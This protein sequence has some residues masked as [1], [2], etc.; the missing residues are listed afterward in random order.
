MACHVYNYPQVVLFGR[1]TE[2]SQVHV[3]LVIEEML[4]LKT[5]AMITVQCLTPFPS[6]VR[7]H[8]DQRAGEI[9]TVMC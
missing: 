1:S 7:A 6:L 5:M 4:S 9:G 3:L 2:G 8:T